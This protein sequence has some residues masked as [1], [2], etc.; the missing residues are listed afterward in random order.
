M[1]VVP[2]TLGSDTPSPQRLINIRGGRLL[3][4]WEVGVSV[5]HD[6]TGEQNCL[7]RREQA[8]TVYLE[9]SNSF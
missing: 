6:R 7:G 2:T 1:W 8:P 5:V 4:S 9:H 3:L